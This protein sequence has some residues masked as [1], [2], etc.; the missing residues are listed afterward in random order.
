[1]ASPTSLHPHRGTVAVGDDDVAVLRRVEQLI[2]GVECRGLVRALDRALRS[3]DR[4][5]HQCVANILQPDAMRRKRAGI[6]LDP[7]GILLL[8][9]HR[10]W[11]TPGTVESCCARIV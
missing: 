6:D 3:I 8:A 1:M 10:T 7:R 4:R 11:E 2:V 5:R 9:E